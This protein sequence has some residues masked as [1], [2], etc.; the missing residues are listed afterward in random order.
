MTKTADLKDLKKMFVQWD[1]SQDGQLSRDE[2]KQNMDEISAAFGMSEMDVED[3]MLA[4]DT[5]GDG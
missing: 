5:N 4:A 3:L 1:T 2:L